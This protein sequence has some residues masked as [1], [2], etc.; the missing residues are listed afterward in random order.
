M[1]GPEV[2]AGYKQTEVGVIPE[3]WEVHRLGEIEF[4]ISDGNYSSKYPRAS[5][6]R[7][8][9]VP[10]IRASNIKNRT[11]VDEDM[12]FITTTQHEELKK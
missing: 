6:F 9:G 5:D 7:S 12:R 10:F 2:K 4:D 3:N 8:F 11:V 1:T